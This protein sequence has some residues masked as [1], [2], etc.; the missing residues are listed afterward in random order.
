MTCPLLPE[1]SRSFAAGAASER[2]RLVTLLQA[3]RGM[4]WPERRLPTI[5]A[6]MDEIDTMLS[7]LDHCDSL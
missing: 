2:E 1:D 4:L 3:R 5:R 6:A 7:L